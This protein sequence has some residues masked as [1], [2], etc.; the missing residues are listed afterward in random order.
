MATTN[1]IDVVECSLASVKELILLGL[2]S[3]QLTQGDHDLVFKVGIRISTEQ[4]ISE[5]SFVLLDKKAKVEL[6][7]R[8]IKLMQEAEKKIEETY[9]Q[10]KHDIQ[11]AKHEMKVAQ[12][13]LEEEYEQAKKEA[14]KKRE[15]IEVAEKN[16]E[17]TYEQAKYD[18]Y[19]RF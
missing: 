9:E 14:R 8:A 17:E 15:E 5:K 16:L 11:K 10:G 7:P 3:A 19:H 6:V 1:V 12:K 18:M 2:D 4:E 13:N